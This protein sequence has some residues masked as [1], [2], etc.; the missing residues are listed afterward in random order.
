MSPN[1]LCKLQTNPK[2]EE[3][4]L[5][6]HIVWVLVYF[7]FKKWLIYSSIHILVRYC[8]RLSFFVYIGI[9][10]KKP[11]STSIKPLLIRNTA[12][13]H[14]IAIKI[15][16]FMKKGMFSFSSSLFLFTILT[17]PRWKSFFFCAVAS[18]ICSL[19]NFFSWFPYACIYACPSFRR[20]F[21]VSLSTLIYACVNLS[22]PWW[23]T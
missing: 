10:Q 16:S 6:E 21:P 20:M 4:N 13:G 8:E 9:V 23:C 12:W 15:N 7:P 17:F 2:R 14:G 1:S 3:R 18:G 19:S 5:T 22:C 11:T